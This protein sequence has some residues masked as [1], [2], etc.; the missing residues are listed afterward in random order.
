MTDVRVV[1]VAEP[2]VVVR[3]DE[4]RITSPPRRLRVE[5][6]EDELGEGDVMT[7]VDAPSR[8]RRAPEV[9]HDVLACPVP[10]HGVGRE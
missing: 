7:A 2:A 6:V 1:V 5:D 8:R 9:P 4:V 10:V 3:G